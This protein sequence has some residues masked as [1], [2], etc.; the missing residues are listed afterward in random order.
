MKWGELQDRNWNNY[1]E[2]KSYKGTFSFDGPRGADIVGE[3]INKT[4][5]NEKCLD[6]GCGI[7]PLPHYMKI[8]D[9]VEF[10]GIDPYM[11]DKEREFEFIHGIAENLP[12]KD[13]SFDG[14]LFATSLDHIE[15]PA[16]ATNEAYRVLKNNGKVF[17]W[18]A[19]RSEP[20]KNHI[21]NF[22]DQDIRKLFSRFCLID[23][24]LVRPKI[25]N[26]SI[27]LYE[28]NN[29]CIH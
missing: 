21:H 29:T 25:G 16:N 10:I 23:R 26:E 27:Y 1:I 7:V 14:V 6:I 9:S 3:L 15:L 17:L 5:P 22:T 2:S 13:D 19:I 8:A 4:I 20:D 28:K 24:I 18:T 11:G 12:F